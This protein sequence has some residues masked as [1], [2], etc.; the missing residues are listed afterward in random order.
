MYAAK[1]K[2][3]NDIYVEKTERQYIPRLRE[4]GSPKNTFHRYPYTEE[5]EERQN[6]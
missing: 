1:C 6:D 3:C 4:H 2:D 5:E